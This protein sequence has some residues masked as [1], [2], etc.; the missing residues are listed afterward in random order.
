MGDL[1]SKGLRGC[2]RDCWLP[3]IHPKMDAGSS[4][5]SNGRK[6]EDRGTRMGKSAGAPALRVWEM[7]GVGQTIG[8]TGGKGACPL[9]KA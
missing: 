9:A 4:C 7:L 3:S 5:A 1:G 8:R 2:Y 6:G